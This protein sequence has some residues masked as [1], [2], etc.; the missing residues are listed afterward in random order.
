MEE[1]IFNFISA[2]IGGLIVWLIQQLYQNKKERK[3]NELIKAHHIDK[4]IDKNMLNSLKPGTNL[5]V[6]FDVLGIPQKKFIKDELVYQE[7]IIETNSYI[8]IFKN[9]DIKITSKDNQTIDSVTLLANDKTFDI[10]NFVSHLN[11]NS[12][13]LNKARVN[14]NLILDSKS[15][16][17]ASRHDYS[18]AFNYS[19]GNPFSLDITLFGK[20]ENGWHN[21]FDDKDPNLF[22]NG[23]ITGICL[24]KYMSDESF[25]IHQY[26]L[27]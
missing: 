6:M 26:E 11:L 17:I 18:F 4:I 8:Y 22:L 13:V 19:I 7:D 21:Y 20:S 24:S 5:A 25:Y 14:N 3:N 12:E 9:A 23:L 1:Y 16:F 15:T 10:S 2:I 27:R